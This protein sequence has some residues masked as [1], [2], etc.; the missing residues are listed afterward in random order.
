V[1]EPVTSVR[2]SA[3]L[4]ALLIAIVLSSMPG[5]IILP[6]M[7]ALGGKFGAS[8]AEIGILFGIYPLASAIA[9]PAWGR[10][11]DRFGRRPVL[12]AALLCGAVSFAAFAY[13]TS[14][15]GLLMARALQGL[16]GSTRG[17][18]FAVVAD[19]S[20]GAERMAGLGKVSAAMAIGFMLG[21]ACGA[22]FL[23]EA[24]GGALLAL[25]EAVG[26]PA[27]GFDHR[28]P[29]LA[30]A[31][32]N[33]LGVA[34]I[35]FRFAESR[36][37]Q[38]QS[39]DGA[40]PAT[41]APRPVFNAFLVLL[42]VQFVVSGFIQ[43]SFQFSF[44]LW[45]DMDL[46]WSARQI[47]LAFTLLGLAFALA[48]GG[49]LKP[50]GRR[51]TAERMVLVGV[52]SDMAGITGFVLS[53]DAPVPALASLFVSTLGGAVWGTS[54]LGMLSRDASAHHQGLMM[55]FANAAGLVG[56][57]VGPP[58]AGWLAARFGAEAPFLVILCCLGL[59]FYRARKLAR[60]R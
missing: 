45:A 32:L 28:A 34:L 38:T 8:A 31:A 23:D 47:S 30:G 52:S 48:A 11:S 37:P 43:G 12:M 14:F 55:G 26:A 49:L 50:L 3:S 5:T 35:A 15:S 27:I 39:P 24:P 6:M 42:L 9:A 7:P 41:T 16:S 17:I 21:P 4:R 20:R 57:V 2:T 60:A 44:A 22:L 10:L 53:G 36:R 18:G 58:A 59:I 56:R 40:G 51:L 19:V 13:A 25:R 29:S 1:K 54:L 33:L 46:R